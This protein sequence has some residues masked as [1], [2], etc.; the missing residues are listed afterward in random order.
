MDFLYYCCVECAILVVYCNTK[1]EILS[2]GFRE[3]PNVGPC[4]EI[5]QEAMS[6]ARQ[7]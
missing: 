7:L 3:N 4:M 6:H 2:G 5:E 1:L